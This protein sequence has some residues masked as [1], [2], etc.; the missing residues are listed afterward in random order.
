[1]PAENS[2][3]SS[4]DL[5]RFITQHQ[6]DATILPLDEHTLTVPDAARALNV[7]PEQIIKSLVFV[8]R[9]Q[10][11]LVINNGPERLDPRR[12]AAHFGVNRKKIKFVTPEHALEITGYVVGSMPPFGHRRTLPTVIAPEVAA[13]DVVF[14]GGGD[15]NAMMRLAT[16]ELFRVTQ[17]E[18][19]RG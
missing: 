5:Q 19:L 16:A 10:P 17:G 1:M 15:V 6:I 14:G 18:A 7:A 8:V 3:L 13:Q 12:L 11:V 2:Q 4:A 9:E